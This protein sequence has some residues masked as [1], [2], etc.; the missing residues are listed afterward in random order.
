MEQLPSKL[1][2]RCFKGTF[3]VPPHKSYFLENERFIAFDGSTMLVY[4]LEELWI[5][6]W[7]TVLGDPK[8]PAG[9]YPDWKAHLRQDRLVLWNRNGG[10][11]STRSFAKENGVIAAMDVPIMTHSHTSITTCLSDCG[12][13]LAMTN[14]ERVDMYITE[15]WTLLGSWTPPHNNNDQQ[16]VTSINFIKG[17]ARI[18]IG[19]LQSGYIVDIGT[20]TTVDRIYCKGYDFYLNGAHGSSTFSST[21]MLY[22][23]KGILGAIPYYNCVIRSSSRA[24]TLYTDQCI[25]A[26]NSRRASVVIFQA[27]IVTRTIE[28]YNGRNTPQ[29]FAEV[30]V[31]DNHNRSFKKIISFPLTNDSELQGLT[32]AFVGGATYLIVL[33]DTVVFV[34]KA[35][36]SPL[37]GDYELV[38][39]ER[40]NDVGQWSIYSDLRVIEIIKIIVNYCIHQTKADSDVS[41]L[42]PFFLSMRIMLKYRE[43][44]SG[45]LSKT[46]RPF[47][48]IPARDYRF[49][50]NHH[51]LLLT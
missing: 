18:K 37:E 49:V 12:R 3:Y 48:Y 30:S 43:I 8:D 33:M 4:C 38:L 35:L 11:V 27:E 9:L 31:V 28:Y 29:L 21:M 25:F 40:I 23:G 41:F 15:T 13:F 46:L 10:Y 36:G 34:W 42:N 20:M 26:N 45:L 5:L 1:K 17:N 47:A 19:T 6:L 24:A 14:K 44:D 2:N 39:T 51:T 16:E 22:K 32:W 50:M 7:E